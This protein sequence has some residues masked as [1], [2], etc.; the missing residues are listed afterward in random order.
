MIKNPFDPENKIITVKVQEW[1]R[2][3][4]NVSTDVPIIINE[5]GCAD[6]SCLCVQTLI[7]IQS[8]PVRTVRIGKP[9]TLVRKWDI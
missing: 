1:I 5:V 8:E 4:Y 6:A 9:L 3:K 7:S 2:L